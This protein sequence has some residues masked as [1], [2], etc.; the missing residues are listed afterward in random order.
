MV[1]YL[2]VN[3]ISR[4]SKLSMTALN[5]KYSPCLDF[6]LGLRAVFE[7]MILRF[8]FENLIAQSGGWWDLS[9]RCVKLQ[10]YH[11]LCYFWLDKWERR[12]NE[13]IW[14]VIF[15]IFIKKF[16]T[17]VSV[18]RSPASKFV[19]CFSVARWLTLKGKES[20][21]VWAIDLRLVWMWCTSCS[22]C[23]SDGCLQWGACKR[24][25]VW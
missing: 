18:F 21:L 1:Y 6:G 4:W 11:W 16:L 15:L 17:I 25:K 12:K 22:F 3:S 19:F 24:A 13:E 7:Y 20:R 14:F 2:P 9:R 10:S 23:S 5:R 8:I